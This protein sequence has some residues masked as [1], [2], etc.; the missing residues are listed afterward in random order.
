MEHVE[1]ITTNDIDKD[2]VDKDAVE[3]PIIKTVSEENNATNHVAENGKKKQTGKPKKN[4]EFDKIT[5]KA[6]LN[7]NVTAFKKWLK[8]KCVDDRKIFYDKNEKEHTPKIGGATIALAA[9][10]EKLCYIILYAVVKSLKENKDGLYYITVNEMI[11]AIKTEHDLRKNIMTYLEM[12]DD[13]L[14]YKDQYCVQD[15][16]INRYIDETFGGCVH[17]TNEAFNLLV[18]ILLKMSTKIVDIAYIIMVYSK[19]KTLT[20]SLIL[21]CVSIL[22]TNPI[23]NVIKIKIEETIKLCNVLDKKDQEDE[24]QNTVDV[25]DNNDELININDDMNDDIIYETNED[26]EECVEKK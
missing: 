11:N 2:M 9:V 21:A 4:H 3:T 24:E 1:Q 18:Y 16:I 5:T 19:K 8:K 25:A 14:C 13:S 15:K 6:K 20:S 10:N 17:M 26:G 22:M 23:A 12:Y 7:F